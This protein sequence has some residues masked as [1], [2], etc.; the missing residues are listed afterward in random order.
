ME[1][2]KRPVDA[3]RPGDC[4][5]CDEPWAGFD[6]DIHKTNEILVV[7]LEQFRRHLGHHLQQVAMFALPR[8]NQDSESRQ[9]SSAAVGRADRDDISQGYRWVR[10]DCGRGWSIVSNS[11]LKFFAFA[12]F[13][14]LLSVKMRK[15]RLGLKQTSVFG[16]S[17]VELSRRERSPVP[18]IVS[19]CIDDVELYAMR[20]NDI[21]SSSYES[22]QVIK[23]MEAFD[24]GEYTSAQLCY[25]LF[26]DRVPQ[27]DKQTADFMKTR[28]VGDAPAALAV[29]LKVFL[30]Q[31]PTPLLTADFAAALDKAPGPY[32]RIRRISF[33][34]DSLPDSHYQTLKVLMLHLGRVSDLR[35]INKMNPERLA[36]IFAPILFGSD[37]ESAIDTAHDITMNRTQVR[38]KTQERFVKR[39]I[40]IFAI[41]STIHVESGSGN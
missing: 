1:Q 37:R 11:R 13:N 16:V 30:K 38:A 10:S 27:G 34:K 28:F 32:L 20:L 6:S 31:L 21:Y 39:L 24:Q 8:R 2:S 33:V 19:R 3:L 18:A 41:V 14:E 26:A 25:K 12:A 40:T 17:L 35:E 4:L 36:T 7:S 29:V 23:L 9:D 15:K 5:F 22:E